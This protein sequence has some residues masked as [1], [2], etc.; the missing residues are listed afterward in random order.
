MNLCYS[1]PFSHCHAWIRNAKQQYLREANIYDW[2]NED[3]GVPIHFDLLQ[4]TYL[5]I[6]VLLSVVAICVATVFFV[7]FKGLIEGLG[8]FIPRL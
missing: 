3:C 1:Y 4:L 8:L 5:D 2:R 6:F 7:E